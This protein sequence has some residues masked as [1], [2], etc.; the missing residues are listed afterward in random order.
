VRNR[1]DVTLSITQAIINSFRTLANPMQY[2]EVQNTMDLVPNYVVTS[3]QLHPI[4]NCEADKILRPRA[5]MSQS[6]LSFHYRMDEREIL[7]QF[8]APT[9]EFSLSSKCPDLICGPRGLLFKVFRC[10]LLG[11]K[12][13]EFKAD[14]SFSSSVEVENQWI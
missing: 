1:S 9:R 11:R 2:C 10:L 14:Q 3:V 5:G 13:P 4:Y 6:V 7:V 8:P 12:R